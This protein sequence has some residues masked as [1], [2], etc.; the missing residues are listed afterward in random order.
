VLERRP[1][2]AAMEP[3]N[4][5]YHI[6]EFGNRVRGETIVHAQHGTHVRGYY[7]EAGK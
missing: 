2:M 5:S 6:S 4:D 7:G 3:G 1:L